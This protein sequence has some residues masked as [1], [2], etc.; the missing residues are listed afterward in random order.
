M[1]EEELAQLLADLEQM[2]AELELDFIVAQEQILG[3]EGVSL[4]FT[5]TRAGGDTGDL[6]L[7]EILPRETAPRSRPV[8]ER[9][10]AGPTGRGAPRFKKGD[11]ALTPLDVRDR[12]AVLLDL[13]EVA[14]AGTLAMERDVS[15]Q[16]EE[17]RQLS[18]ADPDGA[19]VETAAGD[20]WV[21]SWD[22]TIVFDNPPEAALRGPVVPP[23]KL[24][25]E[26]TSQAKMASARTVIATLDELRQAA[27]VSRGKWL[28]PY[29]KP[30]TVGDVWDLTGQSS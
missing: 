9:G 4:E 7:N 22:G 17:F 28:A 12:L 13:I 25:D 11:V 18:F 23:W 27:G 14:T 21:E 26:E 30:S 5:G 3:A 15:D 8:D 20:A 1:D 10:Y 2:L 19:T 16:L 29:G 24:P 6:Y